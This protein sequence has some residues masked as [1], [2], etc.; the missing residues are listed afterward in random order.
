MKLGG[1]SPDLIGLGWS[2]GIGGFC[3]CFCFFSFQ[4]ILI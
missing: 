4:A 2:Q 3:F 1:Q